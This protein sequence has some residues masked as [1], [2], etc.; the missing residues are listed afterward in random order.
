MLYLMVAAASAGESVVV[1]DDQNFEERG[2]AS[3]VGDEQMKFTQNT[4]AN[5]TGASAD[6]AR[7]ASSSPS[8][9]TFG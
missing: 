8:C 1:S 6:D 3:L 5:G 4:A 7:S 9:G 2:D